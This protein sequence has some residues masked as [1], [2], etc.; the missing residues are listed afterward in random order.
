[1]STAVL[2]A[3]NLRKKYKARTVVTDVSFEVGAGEVVG[4]LG[5]NGAGKTTCFYMIVGLVAAD[6]GEIRMANGDGQTRLTHMP[7]HQRARLGLSYLPQENS[8][9][10]KLTVAENLR[11]VLELQ[12]LDDYE[13]RDREEVLL[14]ELHITHIRDSLAVSLSG[15]ER[16]RVEIARALATSPR[17]ILLDEPFAGV[18]P[19]AVLDIQKIIGYLKES[20]IGVLITDHNVRETLGICD[21]AT[22]INAGEVLAAGQP[23]EIVDNESVRRVYLGEH[24]RM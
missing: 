1:M 10:R 21:R 5:P 8:V 24:F 19:I 13:M 20:G 14:Q 17:F 23:A 6:G 3:H 4:L 9:F 2:S 12:G 7:I 18:D 11:A 15:G 22:I 16:R